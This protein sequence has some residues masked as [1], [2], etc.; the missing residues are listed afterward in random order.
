MMSGYADGGAVDEELAQYSEPERGFDAEKFK[1]GIGQLAQRAWDARPWKG[2]AENPSSPWPALGIAAGL[3]HPRLGGATRDLA[4]ARHLRGA[5]DLPAA[6]PEGMPMHRRPDG[7]GVGPHG[8]F[9]PQSFEQLRAPA[10]TN[11][12]NAEHMRPGL[13]VV[14]KEP[15]APA[16]GS[17]YKPGSRVAAYEA[18]LDGLPAGEAPVTF[19]TFVRDLLD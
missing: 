7:I 13:S 5:G 10:N 2:H 4:M 16:A 17:P 14:G 8:T 19:R 18:Y 12:R 15:S 11:V 3:L 6:L 1:R 9:Q